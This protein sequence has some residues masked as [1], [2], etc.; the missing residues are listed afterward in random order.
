[1]KACLKFSFKIIVIALLIVFVSACQKDTVTPISGTKKATGSAQSGSSIHTSHVASHGISN[2][3][4]ATSD[5]K[6]QTNTSTPSKT[7][8]P[9]SKLSASTQSRQSSQTSQSQVKSTVNSNEKG[10]T[11]KGQTTSTSPSKNGSSNT[12]SVSKQGE[13][14]ADTVKISVV[15]YQGQAVIPSTEISVSQGESLLDATLK[16]LKAKGI[17]YSVRGSGSMAYVEGI[18]NT[19]E[20]DHGPKSGWI[21]KKNGSRL[22]KSAGA[23]AIKAGD[24]IQWTYT[25][26][27]E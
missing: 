2:S 6:G 4:P 15:G 11:A 23:E 7:S 10:Q 18:N 14:A 9:S 19:Y 21:A 24:V 5:T 16:L 12:T 26:T 13:K 8:Q 27:G 3:A 20:F 22:T 17:Q 25:T 1:M